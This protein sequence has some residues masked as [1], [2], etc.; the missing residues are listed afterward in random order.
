VEE[1]LRTEIAGS[2][3]WGREC[4]VGFLT[5]GLEQRKGEGEADELIRELGTPEQ[6]T[7][8]LIRE[9]KIAEAMKRIKK[10]IASAP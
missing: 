3:D 7:Y 2:R 6:K 9:G 8:L 4:L 1:R 10:I 5:E